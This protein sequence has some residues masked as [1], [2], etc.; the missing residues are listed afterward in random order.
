SATDSSISL[1]TTY[2]YVVS[3]SNGIGNSGN[4]VEVKAVIPAVP[5]APA[6]LTATV[7]ASN[8]VVLTWS[9]SLGATS[10]TVSRSQTQGGPYQQ[11]ALTIS[12]TSGTDGGVTP[13]LAY[14]YVVTASDAAGA[15]GN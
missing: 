14:F 7:N 13:G 4:S 12:G 10:Y 2:Y 5:P 3:A 8:Q 15:S 1:G 6:T 11:L 9:A